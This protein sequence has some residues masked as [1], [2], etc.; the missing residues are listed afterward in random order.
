LNF[1]SPLIGRLGPGQKIRM[2]LKIVAGTYDD[3]KLS[4]FLDKIKKI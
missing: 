4:V 1:K 2:A 3:K